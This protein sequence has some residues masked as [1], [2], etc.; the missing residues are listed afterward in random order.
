[1]IRVL[2]TLFEIVIFGS[3]F[4]AIR[5]VAMWMVNS[6]AGQPGWAALIPFYRQ[7]ILY[8]IAG[9]KNLFWVELIASLTFVGATLSTILAS[10]A[11]LIGSLDAGSNYSLMRYL[12]ASI[13]SAIILF[14]TMIV[15]LIA[16]IL[17]CI[18][19]AKNF[20]QGS[21]FAAGLIFLHTIF[22]CMLA[23]STDIQFLNPVP[24]VQSN[25]RSKADT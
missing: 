22:L 23:F 4:T 1:M 2:E 20:D 17:K 3:P 21:G 10:V 14:V 15:L 12:G 19:L 9:R 18:G 13:I 8:K 25:E 6:K 16:R 5:V 11:G 7:Y 24:W